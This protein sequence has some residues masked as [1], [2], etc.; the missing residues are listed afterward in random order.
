VNRSAS[1]PIPVLNAANVVTVTRLGLVPV[2]LLLVV[3][4]GMA[5]PAWRAAACLAFLA[6]SLTDFMDGWIARRYGLVTSFGTIADPIADKAL[7]GTALV[8]LSAY[9]H[10]SWLVTVVI[11][12]REVGVTGIRFW[13]I[14]Q[15][16][17]P[18]S[19][20]GK[21]K[22]GVQIAAI[23]WYLWPVPVPV[24]EPLTAV[25]PSLMA[26]AVVVTVVTGVDYVLRAWRLRRPS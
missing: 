17:I 23:A 20:G 24:P 15:G 19:R 18:A 11:L 7:T 8:L 12:V 16:V 9:G 21:V 1:R 13:V 4:S 14:R 6:A 3:V 2:F 22:T 25:G 5:H 10:L 26:A